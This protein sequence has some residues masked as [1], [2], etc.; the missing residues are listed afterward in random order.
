MVERSGGLRAVGSIVMSALWRCETSNWTK[1]CEFMCRTRPLEQNQ[2]DPSSHRKWSSESPRLKRKNPK[3]PNNRKWRRE[4]QTLLMS[5]SPEL[6]HEEEATMEG[7]EI[8]NPPCA[9]SPKA[10]PQTPPLSS[11]RIDRLEIVV[12]ENWQTAIVW[13]VGVSSCQCCS[14]CSQSNHGRNDLGLGVAD[15]SSPSE[16]RLDWVSA[17]H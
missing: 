14:G 13:A 15:A 6:S 11:V 5:S 1:L 9:V 2:W 3:D 16:Q 17:T 8:S 10:K 4:G 7:M 12:S